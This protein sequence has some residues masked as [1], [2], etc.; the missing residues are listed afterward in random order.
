MDG[1]ARFGVL[2]VRQQARILREVLAERLETVLPAAMHS[3]GLDMWLVLCQ[4]DD[5]DP[6]FPTL[7]PMDTW[8]PILQM[9]VFYDTGDQ[10]ERLNLSMTNT[11]GLY[12]APWQGRRHEEQWPLLAQLVAA[13]DP[14]RIGIN[15]G[16]VQWAAGGLTHNLYNQLTEA[17]APRYVERLESAEALVT[18]WAAKLCEREIELYGHVVSVAHGL[19]AE[20]LSP[21]A[22]VPGV[23]TTEDLEWHYWQRVAD[24]GLEVAFKPFFNTVRSKADRD[25][26]GPGDKVIR[27]GD[28]V[29]S[30]VG[31]R[32]LGLNSDHQQLAYILRPGEREAPQ[33]LRGL[34]AWANRLQDVFLGQ[35]GLGLSGNELLRRIL[36]RARSEALPGPRV[37]SH[38]LGHFLH[39]PGPLIGLPWE[40]TSCPGRGDVRLEHNTSFTMELS[41]TGP[42]PEWDGQEVTL[43]MEEDVV[44]TAEGCRVLG[45]RQTEPYLV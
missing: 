4:E 23:T 45:T 22:I 21:A 13:R 6:L 17:L 11:G 29:H 15:I 27:G 20:C 26:Y 10:V 36:T 38:S 28:I 16:S 42:L 12:E 39:E 34:V 41:V 1:V 2:P 32:Y 24:L 7:L 25:K 18:H 3:A 9:L 19:L 33:G 37:Y 31:I 40:Q 35:F 30:D 14:A 8:C 5:L 44:F 43:S